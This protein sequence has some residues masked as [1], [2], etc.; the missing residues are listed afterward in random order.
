[1]VPCIVLFWLIGLHAIH[2]FIQW[3]PFITT[4]L[5]LP[6]SNG[7]LIVWGCP[8]RL[9]SDFDPKILEGPTA[10]FLHDKNIIL[11]G[12]PSGHQNQNGLVERAWETATNMACA[13]IMDMQMPKRFWY[14]SLWQSIQVINYTPCIFTK[15]AGRHIIFFYWLHPV[16][17]WIYLHIHK[18]CW[19]AYNNCFYWLP[20]TETDKHIHVT[21]KSYFHHARVAR[22]CCLV[23]QCAYK[24]F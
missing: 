7:L 20:I 4:Q 23:H 18:K 12:A 3:N 17:H 21:C 13:F 10:D 14:W 8:S 15:C 16:D 5:N 11:C 6:F 22:P 2:G 24:V 1:M 9:Y 19:K